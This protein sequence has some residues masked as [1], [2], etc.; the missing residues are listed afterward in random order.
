MFDL[1]RLVAQHPP[2]GPG[3]LRPHAEPGPQQTLY[4]RTS[5]GQRVPQ[6]RGP[7]QD[8]STRVRVASPRCL[9][10]VGLPS[11]FSPCLNSPLPPACRCGRTVTSCGVRNADDRSRSQK[12]WPPRRRRVR[13]WALTTAAATLLRVSL[14]LEVSKPRMQ[15]LLRCWVSDEFITVPETACCY[16]VSVRGVENVLSSLWKV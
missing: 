16:A 9:N 11:V 15:L 10:A 13:R 8:A 5:T 7:R 6:R 4:R 1:T 14:L 2:V 12:K 3:P